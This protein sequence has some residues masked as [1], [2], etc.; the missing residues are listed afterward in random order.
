MEEDMNQNRPEEV[1]PPPEG[2]LAAEH[3]LDELA[4]GWLTAA[5]PGAMRLSGLVQLWWA[6]YWLPFRG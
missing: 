1:R 3:S 6:A 5:S 2:E 4:K